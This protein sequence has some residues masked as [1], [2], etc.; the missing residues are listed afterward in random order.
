M[1]VPGDGANEAAPVNTEAEVVD[2]TPRVE[3][4]VLQ[5]RRARLMTGHVCELIERAICVYGFGWREG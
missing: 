3:E 1:A 5:G 2:D 4:Q